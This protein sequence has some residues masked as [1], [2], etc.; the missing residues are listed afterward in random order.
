[1]PD[2]SI[3]YAVMEN[4]KKI[5]LVPLDCGWNDL[6]SWEAIYDI[7]EK[8]KNGNCITGNVIDVNSFQELL[9]V[10]DNLSVPIMYYVEEEHRRCVFYLNHEDQVFIFKVNKE[11][12]KK[13][14]LTK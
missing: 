6:G 7:S 2:I 4:S 13:N 5:A 9:D 10:H 11:N 3:D 12:L 8:D 1:M 14:K